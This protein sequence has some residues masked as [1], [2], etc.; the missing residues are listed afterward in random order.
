MNKQEENQGL[1]DA[2]S[3]ELLRVAQAVLLSLLS[4]ASAAGQRAPET[5][6]CLDFTDLER[7]Q[8]ADAS[9]APMKLSKGGNTP[10][11]AER[12]ILAVA[13]VIVS[14]RSGLQ[15]DLNFIVPVP[16]LMTVS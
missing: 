14:Q 16:L 3:E 13:L 9:E 7:L 6:V 2:M 5:T 12:P 8:H 11:Y 10:Y 1:R 4:F 15:G